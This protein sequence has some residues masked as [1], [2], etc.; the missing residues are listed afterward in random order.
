MSMTATYSP[1][2]NK[3]R[4]YSTTR[5]DQTTYDRAKAAGFRWAPKQELFFATWTPRGED[6]LIELCGEIGDE[7][8]SLVTRAE[9][10]ADRFEGYSENRA[11]D[12]KQA[13]DAV[14]A[15]GQRFEFGQPI[16]VGHHSERKARK[17]AERMQS[18]MRKAVKAWE[19]SGYWQ[20]RAEGAL[21]H[22][23]Y[24]E[25]PD[26]RARRIKTIEADKR[27]QERNKAEAEKWLRG[28]SKE[29]LTMEQAN[30]LAN[31]CRLHMPRIE[32]DKPDFN[33]LPSAYDVLNNTYPSL[34]A[35]RTL[36]QVVER[37]KK[38]YPAQIAW[39]DRWITHYENRLAYER[40]MLGQKG[41]IVA[42][43]VNGELQVE[44]G[45]RVLIDSAWYTVLRV[46]RKDGKA[47]SVRTNMRY[48]PVRGLEEIKQY[49]PP[50]AEQAQQVKDA[51]KVG[52][53]VN[54]PGEGH[55]HITTEQWD[56]VPKDYR[57]LRKV[58]GGDTAGAYRVRVACG[59]WL[60]VDQKNP[61]V[62]HEF[63]KVFITDAKRVDPPKP[64]ADAPKVPDPEQVLRAPRPKPEPVADEKA[65]MDAEMK[66]VKDQLK[67]GIAVQVVNAPQLFPTPPDL[68]RRMVELAG[69]EPGER[70]LE[71]SAGTG[72]ILDQL[73]AGCQV[74]A[75]EI[76]ATLG[77]RLDATDRAVVIGDF[78]VCKPDTLWGRF[79][80]VLMNPPFAKGAD[81]EHIQHAL[82]FLKPGGRL[83]A[84]CA[85]GPRQAQTLRPTVE[86]LGG[87]WEPL[88]AGTFKEEG[89]G[90][91]S[92]LLSLTMP[93]GP[94]EPVPAPVA[95]QVV[96]VAAVALQ[97]VE[98]APDGPQ[99]EPEALEALEPAGEGQNSL[100]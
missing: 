100:F 69:V 4:L 48:V 86:S 44:V 95:A 31:V 16:L 96:P 26:V 59:V 15:I 94:A 49:E 77:G 5:L 9:E 18:G 14:Q 53:T 38:A 20:D 33:Q 2:D 93:P 91:N 27:K 68:A 7:D 87:T 76:N 57:A 80:V 11:R 22:A 99:D 39:A 71:P 30:A 6:L 61:N 42:E 88:P 92:V 47:V 29:G 25:R 34:Y 13:H 28:W 54:Y 58:R 32:G 40:A 75:V 12:A 81:I 10:R 23:K 8:T 56:K 60:P 62:R 83:V 85:G 52:P 50:T 1:D 79:D 70:V 63:H 67:K 3:L 43:L 46:N 64:V 51:T 72:R 35:P 19:T 82:T 98:V 55:V 21:A 90:V 24:L 74:V 41:G 17:D 73:P 36:E 84:I 45:G 97:G 78:L 89:T 65:A 66:A 37:A